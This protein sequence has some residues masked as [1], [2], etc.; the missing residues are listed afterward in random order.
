VNNILVKD[1]QGGIGEE[2]NG[3][4]LPRIASTASKIMGWSGG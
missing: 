4:E 2:T 3:A 1:I